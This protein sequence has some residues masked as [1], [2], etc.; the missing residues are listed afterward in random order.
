MNNA[1]I[2]ARLKEMGPLP[3][4]RTAAIDTF[5]LQ[6]FDKLLQQLTEPLEPSHSLALINL[7]PPHDAS[8]YEVEWSLVHA[9]ENISAEALRDIIPLANDTEVKRIIKI[10]LANYFK[11][12]PEA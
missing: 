11:S 12:N 5:P 3:D 6:E 7:G 2:I 9:A 10:R 8:T 4:D 1:E